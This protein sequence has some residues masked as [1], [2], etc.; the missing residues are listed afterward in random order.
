M[1]HAVAL[2][3]S[4]ALL[5]GCSS[6]TVVTAAPPAEVDPEAP[7]AG[8]PPS[9]AAAP[10][11]DA[12]PDPRSSG[13]GQPPPQTGTVRRLSTTAKG[14]ARAYHVSVPS[15][16][17]RA[18][19]HALVFMLHGAT[20]T[21]PSSMKDWFPVEAAMS[22]A[23][24]VYP[25]AL[26]RTRA[27]GTGGLVTRWDLDGD[28]DLAF[29]DVMLD[30]LS[31]ALCLDRRHVFVSGFSSGGNLA[32]QLACLRRAS[33]GG[34]APVAGPGPFAPT[35]QGPVPVWMTHDVDDDALP[36]SGAR[37]SRDFWIR[38]NGCTA[39][40]AQA[41]PTECKRPACPAGA[42]LVYCESRGVKH[43]VPAYAAA[44]IGAFFESLR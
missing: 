4:C 25:E 10:P 5:S 29:F 28:E 2:L 3:F 22:R 19:P 34:I 30:E 44:A 7:E 16:Y 38:E 8:A 43:D 39:T 20:D 15:S 26:P 37:S 21:N 6:T 9:D 11:P 42:P 32:H 27:D 14:K 36:V 12:A 24:F 31:R 40:F 41:S 35:C 17:D 23:V 13:C 18:T 33:V 1:R